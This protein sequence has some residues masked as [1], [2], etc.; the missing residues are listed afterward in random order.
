MSVSCLEQCYG[1]GNSTECRG[2]YWSDSFPTPEGYYGSPGGQIQSA[3]IFYTRPLTE[4]DLEAAPEGQGL[5]AFARNI[6]C[7]VPKKVDVLISES[8]DESS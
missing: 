6:A 2:V 1:Y 3:C 8:D 5:N 7:S 4:K